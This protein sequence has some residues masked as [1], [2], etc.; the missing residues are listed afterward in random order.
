MNELLKGNFRPR[1]EV[2]A[3]DKASQSLE[4]RFESEALKHIGGSM[5]YVAKR[6]VVW[7]ADAGE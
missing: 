6:K 4:E 3:A 2:K 1:E 7:D 5:V